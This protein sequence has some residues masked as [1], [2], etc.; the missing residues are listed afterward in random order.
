M[1]QFPR[2]F[3]H[4]NEEVSAPSDPIKKENGRD[5]KP[6]INDATPEW[7]RSGDRE[8]KSS[9][10]QSV[11]GQIGWLRTHKSGRVTMKIRGDLT[12][13]VRSLFFSFHLILSRAY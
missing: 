1:F 5:V 3:P 6:K 2:Q 7:G 11:Q 10:W 4:F 8:E 13:E 12:F 9:R